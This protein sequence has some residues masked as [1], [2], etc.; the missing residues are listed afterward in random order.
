MASNIF[1]QYVWLVNILRQYKRLSFNE[2]RELWLKSSVGDGKDITK[3][4][5]YNHCPA[6]ED[7]FDIEIKCD[8][9]DGYRYYIVDVDYLEE[10]NTRCWLLGSFATLDQLKLSPKLF[11]RIQYEDIP[12]GDHYLSRIID[13]MLE[14]K[15]LVIMHQSFGS[16][17]TKELEVEPYALRIF[18]RRWY[19]IANVIAGNEIR[20][21]GLDRI[22][23]LRQTDNKFEM[24]EG[25]S[26][27]NYFKDSCGIIVDKNIPA[28]KVV[29]KVYDTARDYVATL[30]LHSSQ[31]EIARDG[32]STT[33]EFYLSP[34]FNFKQ[35]VFSQ[36]NM[37]EVLEPESLRNEIKDTVQD[38]LRL[39][40]Q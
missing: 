10:D 21:Y 1:T 17:E 38:M 36:G 23:S 13:S 28:Q 12:S 14:N 33:Y 26:L 35:A 8:L 16:A 32:K 24:P 25:F 39:Y 27:K 37:I 31:K 7:I 22:H 9:N 2:I 5:F 19:L 6:S 30:P 29:I 4:T 11:N 15:T 34:D 40:N 20:T 18:A 3:R